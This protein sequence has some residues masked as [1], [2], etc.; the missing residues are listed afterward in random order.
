[1]SVPDDARAAARTLRV[2]AYGTLM[3]G[4]ANHAH[5]C[6]GALTVRPAVTW[7]LLHRWAPGIP[8]LRV[9]RASVFLLGSADLAAD[10]AAAAE[11]VPAGPWRPPPEPGAWREIRGELITFAD[12]V[13]RLGLLDAFE[14]VR[15]RTPR[16]YD[17]VLIPVR[18]LDAPP[19]DPPRVEAAWAYVTPLGEPPPG[20]ALALDAWPVGMP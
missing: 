16:S 6:R 5:F 20:E 3:E 19:S 14:G 1:M 9:A 10:L 13:E 17:R 8:V 2:F 11:Q 4:F 18:R 12:G 15:P 7:G